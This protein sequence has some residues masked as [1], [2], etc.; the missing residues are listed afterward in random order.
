[1]NKIVVVLVMVVSTQFIQSQ[2]LT[3]NNLKEIELAN[4]KKVVKQAI[5]YNDVQ[6]A[7]G[8]MHQIIAIEGENSVYKDSLAITYY[9]SGNFVSSHLLAKELLLVKPS[10][11]KLLE[12][13]AVSLQRLNLTKEAIND[14]EILFLK[15]NNMVYGYQ[16]AELQFSIK[17][18]AEAQNTIVKTITCKEIENAYVQFAIGKDKSQ[19]VSLKAAAY[20]LQG[21]IFFEL[22]D[23]KRANSAFNEALKIMPEFAT[24]T[25]NLNSILLNIK[26]EKGKIN[27]VTKNN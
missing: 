26:K 12:I 6:T 5:T 13:N 20:N 23:T 17:R 7:I 16:L 11:I 1:M 9:Q 21:L 15:T 22:K 14:Y 18:L 8:G 3:K 10:S 25:Q 19:N 27:N 24:A 4:Y 2:K